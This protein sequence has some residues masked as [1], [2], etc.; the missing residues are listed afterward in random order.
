MALEGL[1]LIIDLSR[2]INRNRRAEVLREIASRQKEIDE[3]KWRIAGL[4]KS[5]KNLPEKLG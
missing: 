1:G 5:L 3:H 2:V 4:K